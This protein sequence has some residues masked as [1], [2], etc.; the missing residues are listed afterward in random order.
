MLSEMRTRRAFALGMRRE[1]ARTNR[2]SFSLR[3]AG[4]DAATIPK[5]S[6]STRSSA[7]IHNRPAPS[8]RHHDFFGAGS[9][10]VDDDET[11]IRGVSRQASSAAPPTPDEP[12][13]TVPLYRGIIEWRGDAQGDA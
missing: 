13:V 11:D 4:V 10:T 1:F 8:I 7:R 12:R 6:R 9:C 2:Q 5:L 3:V